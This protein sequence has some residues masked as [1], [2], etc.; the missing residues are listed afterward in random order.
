MTNTLNTPIE[1]LEHAYPLEVVQYSLRRNSGGKGKYQGGDGIIRAYR[2][3]DK[4][5]VSLL[6]ER[7]R[8]APYGLAGGLAGR[9]GENILIR[10]GLRTR[11]AGK[12]NLTTRP[13]DIL[14]IK[15]PSGGGWG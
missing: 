10:N 9:R 1:A 7:R 12:T 3:L 4:A 6:T 13:Q 11:L 15:T 5:N 8:L 14:V 2:F